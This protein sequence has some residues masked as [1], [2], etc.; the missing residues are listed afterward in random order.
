[1]PIEHGGPDYLYRQLA[2]LIRDRIRSGELPSRSQVPPITALAA[3]HGL[4]LV[5]VRRAM[6]VLKDEGLIETYPGRGTFVV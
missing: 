2:A 6:A 1:V 5:T 3:E 4:S